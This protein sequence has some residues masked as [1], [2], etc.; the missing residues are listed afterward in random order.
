[1]TLEYSA[2]FRQV[3]EKD[4]ALRQ[5]Y[6][7]AILFD[8]AYAK[9]H[10][11]GY[12]KDHQILNLRDAHSHHR[13]T[14]MMGAV[15]ALYEQVRLFEELGVEV[16]PY[17]LARPLMLFVGQNVNAGPKDV[18]EIIGFLHWML[19]RPGEA[20][21]LMDDILGGGVKV[22]GD[23]FKHRYVALRQWGLGGAELYRDVCVRVFHGE[24][25]LEVCLLKG[26]DGEIGL[27]TLDGHQERYFGVV[28]VG[29]ASGL[30]KGLRAEGVLVGDDDR[31]S[32]SIFEEIE[33]DSS[34]VH[35]L[36]GARKFVEGWSSWRVS[37]MGLLRV[38]KSRGAQI[39]QL[40]GRGVRLKGLGGSLKRSSKLPGQHPEH[41]GALETLTIFG[42]KS[43]YLQHFLHTLQT[44]GVEPEETRVMR[45]EIPPDWQSKGLKIIQTRSDYDFD[46][47]QVV[48][49]KDVDKPVTINLGVSMD[50]TVG[51][52]QGRGVRVMR[53]K[54]PAALDGRKAFK[55]LNKAALLRHGRRFKRA[56]RWDNVYLDRQEVDAFFNGL[57]EWRFPADFT[58]EAPCNREILQAA[59]ASALEKGI[60]RARYV[61]CERSEKRHIESVELTSAHANFPVAQE[62]R[63]DG[64]SHSVFGYTVHVPMSLKD[65]VD[66]LLKERSLVQTQMQCVLPRL[67]LQSHLFHPLALSGHFDESPL[68]GVHS[69]S[70]DE[71]VRFVPT[72]LQESEVQFALDVRKAWERLDGDDRYSGKELWVLRNVSKSGVGFFESGGFYPDF[73]VWMTCGDAQ[74]LAFV[75]PKGM[76][77][78]NWEKVKLKGAIEAL[79]SQAGFAMTS[80]IVTR[81]PL[82]DIPIHDVPI[83]KRNAWL[84]DRSVLHQK[85]GVPYVEEIFEW[86]R[87]KV[88]AALLES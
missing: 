64:T 40:F 32:G 77:Y 86:L 30:L 70:V 41:I 72:G 46:A 62:V 60:K 67:H 74:A 87:A 45:V 31:I 75:D 10:R 47:E 81:T 66:A 44:E 20:T 68:G 22:D 79:S 51:D 3:T 17:G 73:L 65:T 4:E 37:V 63:P 6:G 18:Q 9:F 43:D 52:A 16:Q 21:E 11:D 55:L 27:R 13:R 54:P 61:K 71:K 36:V 28:S 50:T 8:Y 76:T 12:G 78:G 38:G 80:Y 14:P 59:A 39:V 33:N 69:V 23:P 84:A 53:Q 34:P 48:R 5:E 88:D 26:T 24:G 2:T 83:E 15:L 82:E 56:K 35:M 1:M 42:I 19:G 57:V 7:K 85:P 58:I 29:N 25:A 49:L